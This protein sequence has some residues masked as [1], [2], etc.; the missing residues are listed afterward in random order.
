MFIYIL[1]IALLYKPSKFISFAQFNLIV[2]QSS[3]PLLIPDPTHLLFAA[4]ST[5]ME[6]NLVVNLSNVT[7]TN[8]QTSVLQKG[9]K[10][11][12][13]PLENDPGLVKEDL[14]SFDR[15][16]R[17][18]SKFKDDDSIEGD[19]STIVDPGLNLLSTDPFRH[20]KLKNK[21]TFN[22]VGPPTLEAMILANEHNLN[23][24]E[25]QP[26]PRQHNISK[27]ERQ[28]IKDLAQ[29][30]NILIRSADKGSSVCILNLD[31][32]IKHGLHQ[33]S[34]SKFYQKVDLDLTHKRNK[35]IQDVIL[36]MFNQGEIDISVYNYLVNKEPRTSTIYFLPKLHKA[37][38]EFPSCHPILSSNSS[39]TERISQFVDHFLNPLTSGFRSFVKDTTHFLQ[40]ISQLGHIPDDC[41]LVTLDVKSLYTNINLEGGFT[42]AKES[43][44]IPDPSPTSNHPTPVFYSY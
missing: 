38:T 35:E 20:Q 32:Y 10:F 16:L 34:N 13:T 21:S 3:I 39:A 23:N 1:F 44:R 15:K 11:C 37:F 40:L 25:V 26:L 29:N 5:T 2:L 36:H 42:A 4:S 41:F 22:P 27:E 6:D 19:L 28:A 7:L 14:D 18:F 8:A 9:L 31:Q 12:P 30:P 24:R 33:L 43:Y 17:L